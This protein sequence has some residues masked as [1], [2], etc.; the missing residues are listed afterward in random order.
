MKISYEDYKDFKWLSIYGAYVAIQCHQHLE[1]GK[2]GVSSEDMKRI[3]EEAMAVAD[4]ES[5]GDAL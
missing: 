1:D 4:L 3:K 5:E 2:G